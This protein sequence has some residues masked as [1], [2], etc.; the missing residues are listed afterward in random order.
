M[1]GAIDELTEI[2]KSEGA[3]FS[4]RKTL[5]E[6]MHNAATILSKTQNPVYTDKDFA[7][8]FG[9]DQTISHALLLE[10][11]SVTM[12]EQNIMKNRG[13]AYEWKI[14]FHKAVYVGETYT[15]TGNLLSVRKA[16][17]T[18]DAQIIVTDSSGN[19]VAVIDVK[20]KIFK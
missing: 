11:M 8:N 13:L 1:P 10:F 18:A 12:L 16:I 7:V 5:T 9:Y 6:D 19:K 3:L 4:E 15:F 2:M 20:M 17:R 14:A